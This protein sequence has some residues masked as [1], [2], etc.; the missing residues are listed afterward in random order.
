M[1][2]GT[3]KMSGVNSGN[4]MKLID[5]RNNVIHSV[6]SI[7]NIIGSNLKSKERK[8]S[9]VPKYFIKNYAVMTNQRLNTFIYETI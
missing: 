4:S 1:K 8:K 2:I 6:H 7:I 9:H 3:T 5:Q